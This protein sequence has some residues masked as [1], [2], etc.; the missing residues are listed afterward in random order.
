M[1][2]TSIRVCLVLVLIMM[3]I[4]DFKYRGIAW[5]FFPLLALLLWFSNT[6]F[7]IRD[8][9]LNVGFLASVYVLLSLWL[10]IKDKAIVHLCRLYLGPGDLLFLL[11]LAF[12]FPP[13]TFFLFYGLSLLLISIGYGL[14]YL[15]S[16]PEKQT[17]PLAGLQGGILLLMLLISWYS[18]ID[19]SDGHLF[20]P[21]IELATLIL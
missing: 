2:E 15:L 3:G 10:S 18:N 6:N 7:M 16:V 21:Y 4:E 5:Y 19:L 9:M 12:Y 11:C 1:V 14:Y 20:E 8:F 13:M 17:I